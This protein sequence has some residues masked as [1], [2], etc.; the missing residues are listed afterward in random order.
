MRIPLLRLLFVLLLLLFITAPPIVTPAAAAAACHWGST[1]CPSPSSCAGWSTNYDCDAAFCEGDD[2]CVTI[3]NPN[4]NA[5]FQYREKFRNCTLQ[6]GSSCREYQISLVRK[7]C[8][9][10]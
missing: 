1:A 7:W 3:P 4:G 9:C 5:T 8:H 2:S 10:P 6:D